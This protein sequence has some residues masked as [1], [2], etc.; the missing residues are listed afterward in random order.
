MMINKFSLRLVYIIICLTFAVSCETNR[1]ETL[2]SASKDSFSIV[3]IPD[4][5]EYFGKDTKREPDSQDEITN[6]VFESQTRWIA[7]NIENQHIVF[8]SHAGDI[9]DKNNYSQWKKARQYMNIIH[10][11]VPYGIS[12]GNHDMASDGNSS[13]FQK[14][15]PA[16]RYDKFDWYGG[17]FKGDEQN[18][19]ISG[20]NANS[21]Q[22]FSAGRLDFII[23]HLECNAPDNVLNWADSII[24][25][26]KNHFAI[27]TTHMFLG[28]LEHPGTPE[29]FYDNPKGVMQWVK[30]H[31]SNGNSPQQMWD[32][33][34]RKHE[35]LHLIFSGDQSRTNAMHLKLTGNKG[36]F[37]HALLS[38]YMSQPGPLRIYRFLPDTKE[39]EIITYNISNKT[40]VNNTPI[41]PEKE[42]HNF[43]IQMDFNFK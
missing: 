37:V 14:Y 41:I 8:V 13:L 12:I 5:Q 19:D 27:I 1:R 9:V 2:S 32:K 10:G 33:C 39:M 15:F 7:N 40:I 28:P 23:L 30:R 25:Q 18:P 29:G 43:K 20:N 26:Y 22:L 34:F 31:G 11:K 6:P 42:A 38:D 35:N 21:Y 24:E 16:S 17:F 4:T 3:V 36:N